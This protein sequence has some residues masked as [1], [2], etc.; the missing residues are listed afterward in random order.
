MASEISDYSWSGN[1]LS[2]DIDVV[3]GFPMTQHFRI[4]KGYALN[5]VICQGAKVKRTIEN[6]HLALTID[7][8][9]TQK[10]HIELIFL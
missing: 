1:T 8:H 4:P 10:V 2:M 5:K 9:K 7:S 6:G 3:G